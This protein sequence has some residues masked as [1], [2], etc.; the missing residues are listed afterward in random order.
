[1]QFSMKNLDQLSL[2]EMETLVS[3]SRKVTWQTEDN[4][5]K[6]TWIAE[7]LKAQRYSKLGKR[8]KESCAGSFRK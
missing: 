2:S 1:M 7:T 5:A 8:A 4:Q 6:Y 3:S